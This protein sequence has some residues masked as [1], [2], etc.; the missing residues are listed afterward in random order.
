[1]SLRLVGWFP[2]PP[3][4]LCQRLPR[5]RPVV[6]FN[7]SG[8]ETLPGRCSNVTHPEGQISNPRADTPSLQLLLPRTECALHHSSDIICCRLR[9][10]HHLMK[11]P[12]LFGVTP[13][14]VAQGNSTLP[15]MN[16]ASFF[17]TPFRMHHII[18][19]AG[20]LGRPQIV[21][22]LLKPYACDVTKSGCRSRC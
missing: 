5:L 6:V 11:M 16:V 20:K 8:S 4:G 10:L 22:L 17:F 13:L 9:L 14:S 18:S 1:M 3:H 2:P 21:S 7:Q 12:S 19:S 15:Q